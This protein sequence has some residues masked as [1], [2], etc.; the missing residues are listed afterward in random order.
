MFIAKHIIVFTTEHAKS[1]VYDGC[2]LCSVAI[3]A[4]IDGHLY[5]IAIT[6]YT[7]R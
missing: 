2:L 7:N 4:D 5:Q 1:F 6:T 3:T